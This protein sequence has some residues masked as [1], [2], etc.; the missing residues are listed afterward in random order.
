MN[1]MNIVEEELLR[2]RIIIL[3]EEVNRKT[4]KEIISNLLYLDSVNHND[5][6]LYV[7]S[8][9]GEVYQGLAIV[10]CM[11]Y[12][13]SKVITIC[14]GTAY[15]MGAIILTCGDQRLSLPNSEILIHEPL[16]GIKGNTT[17]IMNVSNNIDKTRNIL[18]TIISKTTKKKKSTVLKDMKVD[19]YM[20]AKEAL[21]YGLIDNIVEISQIG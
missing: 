16:G 14:V 12:I 8:P 5:I 15:S 11:R 7:N 4:S 10:D 3:N 1:S 17:E 18:A 13:K 20:T 19:N 6:Y 21:K 2:N 9:G